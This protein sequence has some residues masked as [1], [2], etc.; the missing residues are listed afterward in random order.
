MKTDDLI[1]LMSEDAPVRTRLGR[2]LALSI[3]CGVVASAVLLIATVGLRHNLATAVETARVAFKIGA[4]LLLA[5]IAIAIATRIVRPGAPVRPLALALPAVAAL[6]AIAVVTELAVV[7]AQLWTESLMG[8]NAGFCMMFIPVLSLAPLAALIWAMRAGAP[9]DP[10]L[11]GAAAGLAAGAIGASLYAW[12]CPDD[13]PLFVA[14]WYT[15]AIAVVTLAGRA[16]GRRALR[17]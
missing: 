6:V 14:T 7:P 9:A 11:A 15:L 3:L 2:A 16:I 17:W 8:Q 4:T 1:R 13:S 10:G 12:H 5:G